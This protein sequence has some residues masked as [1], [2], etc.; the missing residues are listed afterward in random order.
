MSPVAA[1]FFWIFLLPSMVI[2]VG[3]LSLAK[4]RADWLHMTGRI[5]P[6]TLQVDRLLASTSTGAPKAWARLRDDLYSERHKAY[7]S[8]LVSIGVQIGRVTLPIA[9]I[10]MAAT[11][12]ALALGL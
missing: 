8:R 12:G 7:G 3:A 2:T 6:T 5:A 1:V 4:H 10:A 9:A 11:A